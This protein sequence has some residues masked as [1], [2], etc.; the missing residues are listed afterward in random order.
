MEKKFRDM[1]VGNKILTAFGTIIILY[2]L[3]VLGAVYAA[4]GIAGTLQQ[5]YDEPYTVVRTSTKMSA[6]IQGV[7]R[8][9]LYVAAYDGGGN[10]EEYMKETKEFVKYIEEN[11]SVMAGKAEGNKE[12]VDDVE[13]KLEALKPAGDGVIALLEQ[14]R[15]EEALTLYNS[16]Y[17]PKAIAAI[18]S[19]S[20]LVDQVKLGADEYID[21]GRR[22]ENAMTVM[23]LSVAA[24]ALIVTVFLWHLTTKSILVPVEKIR[25]AAKAISEGDLETVLEYESKDELGDLSENIRSTVTTLHSYVSEI[26]K[27]LTAVGMG[28]LNYKTQISFKGDFVALNR[29]ID[30]ITGLLRESMQQISSSAEQL[31]VGSEQMSNGAQVLSLGASEQAGSVE[32]LAVSINEI[33]DSV[34]NNAENAVKSS[35]LADRVGNQVL[36]SNQQMKR[37]ME[38]IEQIRNNSHEIGG[39]VKEI[40]NI[41]FQTNILSLN[42]SVEAARA[43]EAGRGFSVVA[44]EIRRLAVKVGNASKATAEL[45]M[46]NSDTVGEGMAEARDTADSLIKVVDGMQEVTTIVDRISDAS[47]QQAAA[48]EQIRKSV[49]QI[50]DI[51]QGNSATS[52]ESAATSEELSAQAQLLK[53]LVEQFKLD[54]TEKRGGNS[55]TEDPDRR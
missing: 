10:K 2:I 34:A 41:A 26:E 43:G 47:V 42:A 35:Q 21:S 19:L 7:G 31:A 38:A 53:N 17:E 13:K 1:K 46:K 55:G 52:E 49:E 45:A 36:D 39:I 44:N 11:I 25:T 51:V 40:E 16:E 3:T 12:L 24:F 8:N 6:S 37:M 30:Q 22:V 9:L 15:Y 50:S 28:Q 23:I 20:N 33:A 4:K 29:A 14:D 54:D 5:F 32:E 18:N 27:A 48:I